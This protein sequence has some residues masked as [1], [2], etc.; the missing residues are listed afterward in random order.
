MKT[1]L[2]FI[3]ACALVI[4]LCPRFGLYN[5]VLLCGPLVAMVLFL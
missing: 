4:G 1:W 5:S 3:I 2:I